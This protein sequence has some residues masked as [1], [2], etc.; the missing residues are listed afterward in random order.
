[1]KILKYFLI[2]SIFSLLFIGFFHEINA[3]TQDLG[4]HLINGQI[5]W[6]T[7]SVP[8]TN[9]FSYTYPNFPFINHHW[10]S[11]VIFYLTVKGVGFNG[12]LI[13]TTLIVLIAFSLI[14]FYVFKKDNIIPITLASILY[15]AILF[16]RT[17]LR[18]E[19]FSFL[20]LSIFILVLY[21]Y[22][23]KFTKWIFVLPLIEFLWVNIHIYF[24]V[25]LAVFGLF[26][27]ENLIKNRRS[28]NYRY[29]SLLVVSFLLTCLATLFN[30]NGISGALYP[31]NVFK[32]YGYP[33]EENQNIF[34]LW[35]VYQ[36][37]TVPYFVG[38]GIMLFM[39]LLFSIKRTKLID[40]FLAIFFTVLSIVAVR[41]FPIFV[42][43]TFIIFANYFSNFFEKLLILL[44]KILKVKEN[45]LTTP[46]VICL[47]VI[48]AWQGFLLLNKKPFGFGMEKGA[49]EAALFFLKE[50][51]KG[52]IF[53]NFDI[54]SY[55]DYHFFPREK[56]F[57]DG[58]PEAY[59]ALFIQNFYIPMQTD[60][61]IFEKVVNQ[62]NINTIFFAHTDQTPWAESFM[63]SIVRN[64]NWRLVYL[65]D[66]VFIFV[67]DEPKNKRIIEKFAIEPN[68][69]DVDKIQ[70]KDFKSLLRLTNFF[71]KAEL[72]NPQ[73]KAHQ[74]ILETNP[75][76]C[77]SLYGLA[78]LLSKEQSSAAS[79]YINRFNQ[80]CK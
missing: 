66:Y 67:K 39:S 41:N 13:L 64:K 73:I 79:I 58:R 80:Y 78:V 56:V 12:L 37:P 51:L 7:H 74:K 40:W 42:F 26:L 31:L 65:D 5:I 33:I 17:D 57:I 1:M 20:F 10:L 36:K 3:I 59:P 72:I 75:N 54:G 30:P 43:G 61:K 71:V 76:F 34:F 16:E 24:F 62:Y 38:A 21:R 2:I 22:R 45:Y 60:E 9:F 8:K 49:K 70:T 52:P 4:R 19:I 14:F 25:G 77:P 15:L 35:Q 23:E 47:I 69:I 29:T 27:I 55:L 63:K 68:L 48:I 32:N 46:L 28:L 18:P 11:E 53:N 50:N 6:Q 44:T